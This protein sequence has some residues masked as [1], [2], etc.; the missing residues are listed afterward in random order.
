MKKYLKTT[1]ALIVV[2]LAC[3]ALSACEGRPSIVNAVM[4]NGIDAFTYKNIDVVD[5]YPPDVDFCMVSL[6]IKNFRHGSI[7]RFE[8]L[9]EGQEEPVAETEIMYTEDDGDYVMGL[10]YLGYTPWPTGFYSVNIYI[11]NELAPSR[12]VRFEISNIYTDIVPEA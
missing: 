10:L 6:E 9:Y 3:F 5:G 7:I 4:T 11:E 2:L 8:W 1:R 12:S